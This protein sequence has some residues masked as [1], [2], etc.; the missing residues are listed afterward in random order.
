[1]TAPCPTGTC[2]QRK[3]VAGSGGC[4]CACAACAPGQ[5]CPPCACD[6]CGQPA[7]LSPVPVPS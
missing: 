3:P 7:G 2:V 1:V 5:S 6:C 4:G